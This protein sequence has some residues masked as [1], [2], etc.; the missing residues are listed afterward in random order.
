MTWRAGEPGEVGFNRPHCMKIK[1]HDACHVG[2]SVGES[3]I[4]GIAMSGG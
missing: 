4:A 1:K 2:P 3:R